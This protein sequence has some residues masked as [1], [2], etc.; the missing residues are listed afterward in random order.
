MTLYVIDLYPLHGYK[1]VEKKTQS[2]EK[3]GTYT[4]FWLGMLRVETQE[5]Q[6]QSSNK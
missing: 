2:F 4:L 5:T 1:G 6:K 3:F